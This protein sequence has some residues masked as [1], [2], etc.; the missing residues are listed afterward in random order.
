M[1]ITSKINGPAVLPGSYS[2]LIYDSTPGDETP[3]LPIPSFP[4]L[5]LP[6][7]GLD[8]PS[9]SHI[10]RSPPAS[11]PSPSP[12]T[13]LAESPSLPRRPY[14]GGGVLGGV[15]GMRRAEGRPGVRKGKGMGLREKKRGK[16]ARESTRDGSASGT[17]LARS[18]KRL[19][20]GGVRSSCLWNQRVRLVTWLGKARTWQVITRYFCIPCVRACSTRLGHL[21]KQ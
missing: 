7:S 14:A 13:P 10:T 1:S 8:L 3:F 4:C 16:G 17:V 2:L 21:S 19:G 18:A 6:S 20:G 15:G 11:R 12:T 9:P 5:P